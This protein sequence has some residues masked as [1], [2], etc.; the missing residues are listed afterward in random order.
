[1]VAVVGITLVLTTGT[2]FATHAWQL[3]GNI[4]AN[5]SGWAPS[6][7]EK[8][9]EPEYGAT[10]RYIQ[11]EGY[12]LYWGTRVYNIRS[13]GVEWVFHAFRK[14]TNCYLRVNAN[15]YTWS[16]PGLNPVVWTKKAGC[17]D[18]T[19]YE[20]NEVRMSPDTSLM[21]Q[22]GRYYFGAEFTDIYSGGTGPN[23]NRA[24]G[25]ITFDAYDGTFPAMYKQYL[26]G[27]NFRSD[28]TV[29]N[30]T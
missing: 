5:D 28:D 4:N 16:T 29:A 27:F 13:S 21:T 15:G 14:D 18:T 6:S 12:N 9:Y 11:A 17:G 19:E 25:D 7:G 20:D 24:A 8:W 10:Y 3:V 23:W 1:M 22:D 2:A 30:K 26:G